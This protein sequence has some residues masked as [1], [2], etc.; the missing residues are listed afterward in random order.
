[1]TAEEAYH[2]WEDHKKYLRPDDDF[3]LDDHLAKRNEHLTHLISWSKEMDD[4]A[5]QGYDIDF[6]PVEG[7]NGLMD[8]RWVKR[9]TPNRFSEEDIVAILTSPERAERIAKAKDILEYAGYTISPPVKN[10][11]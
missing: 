9:E 5:A 2:I 8:M 6:V 7:G 10:S 3:W 11:C 4:M 1:M